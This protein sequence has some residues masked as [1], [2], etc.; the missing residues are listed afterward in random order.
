VTDDYSDETRTEA[1]RHVRGATIAW[2]GDRY[3]DF[4]TPNPEV[5]TL[6]DAAYALAYTV[7]WRGQTR[8]WGGGR[9]FY[10]VAQHCVV[11]ATAIYDEGYGAR[12]A[13]AALWHEDDE[14]V[15]PDWPGPVKTDEIRAIGKRQG[16]AIRKRFG[17]PEGDADLIKRFDIRMLVTERRDLM[18]VPVGDRWEVARQGDGGSSPPGFGPLP[19]GA[20]LTGNQ[21]EYWAESFIAH[22]QWLCGVAGVEVLS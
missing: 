17:V 6:E 12:N 5:I 1:G 4:D 13:L 16:D 18:R 20:I 19:T 7:R 2:G 9:Y 11:M 10:G 15:L 22:H 8:D 3:Y 21:P 14:I